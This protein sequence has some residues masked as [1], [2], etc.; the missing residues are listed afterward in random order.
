MQFRADFAKPCRRGPGISCSVENCFAM[1]ILLIM[2]WVVQVSN[3]HSLGRPG[4]GEPG[5]SRKKDIPGRSRKK[6]IPKFQ[7]L[8]TTNRY[9]E[10]DGVSKRL[11]ELAFCIVI[12]QPD[13]HHRCACWNRQGHAPRLGC[14]DLFRVRQPQAGSSTYGC[15]VQVGNGIDLEAVGLQF[16]PYLWYDLGFIPNSRGKKSAANPRPSV[17]R[18]SRAQDSP[19]LVSRLLAEPLL[20]RAYYSQTYAL[21]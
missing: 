16:E 17:R 1:G 21:F 6:D 3:H 5:R 12:C 20:E 14:R 9:A 8:V 18:L 19:T 2:V 11:H 15:L 10:N 7:R 13:R 4:F